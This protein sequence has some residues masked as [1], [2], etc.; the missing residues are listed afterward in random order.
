MH[1]MSL[2]DFWIGFICGGGVVAVVWFSVWL[3]KLV[4]FL[5]NHDSKY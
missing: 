3:T 5:I 2:S 4:S 1:L